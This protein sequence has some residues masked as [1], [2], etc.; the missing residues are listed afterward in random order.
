[1]ITIYEANESDFSG[2]GLGVLTPS[3]LEIEEKAGGMF[4]LS[5]THPMDEDGRW[6]NIAEYCIIKAPA[7]MRETPLVSVG[8]SATTVTRQ[9]YK[10]K[11]NSRLRLRT[12]PSTSKGKIIGR[13]KNGTRVIK[14]DES[15]DW[16]KVIVQEGGA[17]G[18]MHSDYLT[19]VED[20]TETIAGDAPGAV[21]QPRQTREQLFRIISV[22]RDDAMATVSVTAQHIFYDLSG[23][24]VK[25][26][27]APE[28][29]AAAEVCA[30]LMAKAL[31]PHDFNLY[32]TATG[33]VA[34]EYTDAS[35]V[36]ALLEKDI[37]VVP[38]TGARLVRDNYD[39]FVLADEVRDRGVE[40]RHGK[41]LTGAVLTIDTGSVVTR[42]VPV[43]R[44]ADGE[45]LYSEGDGYVD[46]PRAAEIPVVRAKAIE[47]DVS[48]VD[49]GD[50]NAD[51]GKY[52][53]EAEARA[54]LLEL[55]EADFAAGIDSPTVGLDVDFVALEN[56]EEYAQY[57]DLQA[58]HL[59]DTVHVYAA[60]SGITA[61][62]RMTGYVWDALANGGK[63]RYKS[64]TLGD[65]QELETTTYGYDIA[66]GTLSGTKVINGTV[67]GSKLRNASIQYA[68]I[69]VA[70]IEQLAANAITAVSAHINQLVAG[71]IEVDQ[72]Y[73]DLATIAA[74]QIT[75]ANIEQANIDWA[76]IANLSAEVANIIDANIEW[77]EIESLNAS[78]A[79]IAQAK[80]NDATITTAQI[81]DLQAEIAKVI[82]LAAQDG[83]FDFAAIKNLLA[84]A[85][86]LEEGVAGSVYIKNLVATQ[87]NFVGATLG[88]LVL[89][90]EDGGYYQV[91]VQADGTIHTEAVDVTADEISAGVTGGGKQI[92]ATT[93][94]IADLNASTVKAD[95]AVISE[96]FTAALTAGKISASEAFLA[97]ATVPE[98]YVTAISA[99]GD[100]LDLSANESIRLIVADMKSSL[101]LEDDAIRAEVSAVQGEALRPNLLHNSDFRRYTPLAAAKLNSWAAFEDWNTYCGDG[102]L[103]HVR[104]ASEQ[105]IGNDPAIYIGYT[106]T[107]TVWPQIY[108]PVAAGKLAAG[109]YTLSVYV[110]LY[111][112][113]SGEGFTMCARQMN[114]D[115]TYKNIARKLITNSDIVASEW[116]RFSATFEVTDPTLV[117]RMIFQFPTTGGVFIGHPKLEVGDTATAWIVSSDDSATGVKTSY[118][119]ITD[120][121]IDI[122][123][124][125]VL[126]VEGADIHLRSSD[127]FDISFVQ[128][129]GDTVVMNM[130]E[131]GSMT[132]GQGISAP[133]VREAQY[134]AVT[135]YS[136]A[137]GG[138]AGL[139]EYLK[140][141]DAR[142]VTYYCE[143]DDY[144]TRV[145]FNHFNGFLAIK[146]QGYQI[147]AINGGFG[148]TGCVHIQNAILHQTLSTA[149]ALQAAAGV[150]YIDNCWF[151][152]TTIYGILSQYFAEVRWWNNS[153]TEKLTLTYLMRAAYGGVVRYAGHVPGGAVN[154]YNGGYVEK[155]EFGVTVYA[156]ETA[157]TATTTSTTSLTGT[158]GWIC[159]KKSWAT[160]VA[161]QGYT[162][163]KGQCYACFKF[164]LPSGAKTITA[165]KLT[166]HR[167]SGVGK[168]DY[169]DI[170][171]YGSATAWGSKPTLGTKYNE[172]LDA[173]LAGKSTVLDVLTAA[174]ALL[175]G[176]ITQFVLYVNETSTLSGKVYSSNYCAWDSATLDI[177]YTTE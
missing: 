170:C 43:G 13:Y 35:I 118:I 12:A 125:G 84:G 51:E 45:P 144:G 167:K 149:Y 159:T 104:V 44:D 85:M 110:K 99:I 55:A 122:S 20:I 174:K 177:T 173:V 176:T 108:Q 63:G 33:S 31:N 81:S 93:A 137:I 147:P 32:C 21:V 90:G 145:T 23:N 131:N 139:A 172:S 54:R 58:I 113:I 11:V 146:G 29:I 111:S 89:Q 68:K 92:V 94:N 128:D 141:T 95:S 107:E 154:Q 97:S 36:S 155:S 22:E 132:F 16:Y 73:A 47:Y 27:Y 119:E 142:Y 153:H 105:T 151:S 37:G 76:Q 60:R 48:V 65:L 102:T 78:I 98:L 157:S 2:L 40:I 103:G 46:S 66:E 120:D 30:Q 6:W 82:T 106:G 17:T 114:S 123:T 165:A 56:T 39:I 9:V 156:A 148:V 88:E 130:E 3:A 136:S 28:G 134:G 164:T 158:L 168:G 175:A 69:S 115:G 91:T 59:Y 25:G 121:S 64:V 49:K 166:L 138:L 83:K 117:H 96:I 50:A 34:G 143:A 152:G 18:W 112:A 101:T 75:T 161:Y 80:V 24:I 57:A 4:E 15:G 53:T 127:E 109:T 26:T 10:V 86:I 171:L 79:E 14:T 133:N 135:L 124:G 160:G 61:A 1:M 62:L 162:T 42:I 126:N 87:A 163:G 150:W 129:D 7:P 41:N 74:A 116:R 67:G 72:L 140:T 70:A 169:I 5:M 52:A 100:T 8:A 38:Q 19:Y 71:E 77:A